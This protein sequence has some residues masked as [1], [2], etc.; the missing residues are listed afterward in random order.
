MY[1]SACFSI[2]FQCKL[3]HKW[4]SL[5]TAVNCVLYQ[6]N[7]G[8]VD[9]NPASTPGVIEILESLTKHVSPVRPAAHLVSGD[10][11]SFE[12]MLHAV[13][14]RR[15]GAHA[16][17]DRLEWVWPCPQEFHLD[18]Q[19]LQVYVKTTKMLYVNDLIPFFTYVYLFH[20]YN[21]KTPEHC[22]IVSALKK[23]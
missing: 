21:A 14:G 3:C 23:M 19:L 8:T 13:C 7:T 12:K 20:H 18:I 1:F 9:A 15:N 6:I 10:G 11:M 5:N 2:S 4:Q 22:K 17:P 16:I